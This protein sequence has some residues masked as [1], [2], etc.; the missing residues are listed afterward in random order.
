MPEIEG[1]LHVIA[2]KWWSAIKGK[3]QYKFRIKGGPRKL[4]FQHKRSMGFLLE[5][6]VI[7]N[8]LEVYQLRQALKKDFSRLIE[9]L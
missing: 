4:I 6:F 1:V 5:D 7:H 8:F 9:I 3:K 2:P